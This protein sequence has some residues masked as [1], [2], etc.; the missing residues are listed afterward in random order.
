MVSEIEIFFQI[1]S[2]APRR[3]YAPATGVYRLDNKRKK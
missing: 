2:A 3:F 1:G